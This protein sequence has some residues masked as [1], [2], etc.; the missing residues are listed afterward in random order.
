M[1]SYSLPFVQPATLSHGPLFD[2]IPKVLSTVWKIMN[3]DFCVFHIKQ[4]FLSNQNWC[5]L[6][7]NTIVLLSCTTFTLTFFKLKL[8]SNLRIYRYF[9]SKAV[10]MNFCT[11]S[12]FQTADFVLSVPVLSGHCI[13]SSSTD[14]SVTSKDVHFFLSSPALLL[15]C[16]FAGNVGVLMQ[17]IWYMTTLQCLTLCSLLHCKRL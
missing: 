16:H 3:D 13:T 11:S 10:W 9:S 8:I 12:P 1:L 2:H 4:I 15:Y 17:R 6:Y 14:S 7:L 5:V